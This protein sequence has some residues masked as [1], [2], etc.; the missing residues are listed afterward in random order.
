MLT[1]E[2]FISSNESAMGMNSLLDDVLDIEQIVKDANK[3]H[4]IVFPEL[5]EP[6]PENENE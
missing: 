6:E 5:Y 2:N 3:M 1:K 4:R